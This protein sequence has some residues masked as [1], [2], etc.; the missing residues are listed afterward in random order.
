MTQHNPILIWPTRFAAHAAALLLVLFCATPQAMAQ[1][2]RIT[3]DGAQFKPFPVAVPEIVLSGGDLKAGAS[4][5]RDL[6]TLLRTDVDMARFFELVPV[7]T[8]LSVATENM[9]SPVYANWQNVGASGL[10]RASLQTDGKKLSMT[11]RFF[12]VSA[13]KQ[14]L[15]RTCTT[16]VAGGSKCVHQ[17]LDAVIE[18]LTGE[19]GV[20]SSRIA[21]VKRMPKGKAIFSCDM[22]GGN[23][24]KLVDGGS[25]NLLPG[26]DATG[27]YLMFT[28]YLGGNPDM[29]RLSL[30]SGR[31]EPLSRQRGLNTGAAA[32]PNNK[33]LALTLSKDGNTEIY[34]MDW[35]G[36]N[37]T[38]LT[39]SWGQDVS[40]TWSPDSK[41][42][43]FVSSRSG[44][45]HIYVMN[46]DGSGPKR[47]TFRGTYNQE[48]H[49]SPRPDGPIVF[50]A[51]D[52]KLKYDIFLVSAETG[53][54]TRLTQDEANNES[55]DF[56]PDGYHIV[57]TSTRGESG[58]K[59]L[60]VMDID[61]NNPRRILEQ[62]ID[63]ETPV[64]GPRLGY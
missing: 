64:W 2:M 10:V 3:V 9:Q 16:D 40:P 42:I 52:E 7:K 15:S 18:L 21:F 25:L 41:R 53:E 57:F 26:W 54:I 32:A 30:S 12:D 31:I 50:T 35:D 28:S 36:K 55:A 62:A 56:S 59:Q 61:G 58:R 8:Y 5:A 34:A 43:A 48:P 38:R 45:P 33:R 17:F 1:R 46:A 11:L 22:D 44:N 47:L 60:W 19:P 20:F 37:L 14:A 6:L 4:V 24:E 23:L 13:G 39:D 27:K 51:R 63:V 49:W 29:Y